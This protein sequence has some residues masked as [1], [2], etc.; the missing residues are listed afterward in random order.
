M[1]GLLEKKTVIV[2]SVEYV[3]NIQA[4]IGANA[5]RFLSGLS[6]MSIKS[7][8]NWG[9]RK[10]W[11]MQENKK[12]DDVAGIEVNQERRDSKCPG[13]NRF[14]SVHKKLMENTTEREDQ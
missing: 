11:T 4:S 14:I 7:N 1:I 6:S 5:T 8:K 10:R 13:H 9:K 3:D 12:P 2:Q